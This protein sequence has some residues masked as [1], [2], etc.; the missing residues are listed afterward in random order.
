MAGKK[1][2]KPIAGKNTQQKLDVGLYGAEVKYMGGKSSPAICP[3]CHRSI[4]RGMMRLKGDNFYCSIKCVSK[5]I[6]VEASN[7]DN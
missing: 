3:S 5:T 4:V 6:T 1:P 7:E 2:A